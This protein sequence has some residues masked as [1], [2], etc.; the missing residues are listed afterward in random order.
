MEFTT[1]NGV[2]VMKRFS[3]TER[4]R[5]ILSGLSNPTN[6]DALSA[7]MKQFTDDTDMASVRSTIHAQLNKMSGK[8]RRKT[9]IVATENVTENIEIVGNSVDAFPV[10]TANESYY[11][12]DSIKK[13]LEIVAKRTDDGQIMNVMLF[14]AHGCGKSELAQQFAA[15]TKRPFFETNAA[16]FREPRDFFG[17]KGARNGSTFWKKSEVI[18]ALETPNCVVLLDE[19]NRVTN[20]T[21]LNSL[22]SL[23]DHRR[24]ANFD[25][26]GTVRVAEGVTIWSAQNR[27]AMYT[28]TGIVDRA[29]LDRY[30]ISIEVSYLDAEHEAEVLVKRT[31]I[32]KNLAVQL[33]KMAG[34]IR[35]KATGIGSTL[36]ESISTR[37]LIAVAD[38]YKDMGTTAFDYTLLPHYSVEGGASSERGQVLQI[39]SMVFG[40]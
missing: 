30:S 24:S 14:G 13:L 8:V 23:C 2:G 16:F 4:V 6:N 20:P 1:T 38:L 28:G 7:Y 9:E 19:I 21:V 5:S 34:L 33:V 40:S 11:I 17:S 31:G 36:R 12:N 26:L 15:R 25:E 27:G 10:P 37:T 35:Q 32:N 39:I 18:R 3:R 29:L 22:F